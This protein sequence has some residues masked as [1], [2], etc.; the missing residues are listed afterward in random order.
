MINRS[1]R[2]VPVWVQV[3]VVALALLMLGVIVNKGNEKVERWFGIPT[4]AELQAQVVTAESALTA[5][6]D[7]DLK[8]DR[9]TKNNEAIRLDLLQAETITADKFEEMVKKLQTPKPSK[10]K[11]VPPLVPEGY[12]IPS[13]HNVV[14]EQE[15]K[16]HP[17]AILNEAYD[18]MVKESQA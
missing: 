10:H 18:L 8:K 17:I 7:L 3:L 6:V 5:A 11:V 14:E 13:D 4:K 16:P 9:I 12:P 2:I 1:V 15:V